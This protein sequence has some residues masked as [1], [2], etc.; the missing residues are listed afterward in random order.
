MDCKEQKNQSSMA[1]GC[2]FDFNHFI[3]RTPALLP[4]PNSMFLNVNVA[5]CTLG[6]PLEDPG[7]DFCLG[8]DSE[9]S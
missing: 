2:D 7:S 8:L 6:S 1:Q 5:W 4:D 9:V 3:T